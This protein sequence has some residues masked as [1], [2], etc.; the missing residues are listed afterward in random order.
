MYL[1]LKP[2]DGANLI[3]TATIAVDAA[4]TLGIKVVFSINGLDIIV[5][6]GDSVS[7]EVERHKMQF[8]IANMRLNEITKPVVYRKRWWFF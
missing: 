3:D 6:P 7:G 5:V 8:E 1:V 4:N 2:D